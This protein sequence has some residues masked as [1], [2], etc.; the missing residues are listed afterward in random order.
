MQELFGSTNIPGSEQL[1][2]LTYK[3]KMNEPFIAGEAA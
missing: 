2:H 3:Y 1:P